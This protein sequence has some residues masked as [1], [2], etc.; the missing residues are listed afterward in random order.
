MGAE[1]EIRT[2]FRALFSAMDERHRRMW[3][4]TE[5][6][7]LGRGGIAVVARAT[8]MARNTIV[9]GLEDTAQNKTP[10]PHR[11]RK[12]GAGRKRTSLLAP[13]LV[14]ALEKLLE[15]VTRGDPESPLRWTSKSTR[16][17]AKELNSLDYD[18]SHTLV[19]GLLHDL[20]YSLQANR[21]TLEGTGHPDRNA[22]FEY[23][24]EAVKVQLKGGQPAI[25]VDT[26]KKELVGRF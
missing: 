18:V 17:L 6:R 25:S 20:E 16:H 4:G 22:Q 15:P 24:N 10:Y 12:P 21:K 14:T 26:K 2:K 9:R 8:G 23:I 19:A 3:A 7:A 1:Q 5:A 13:G 11:V